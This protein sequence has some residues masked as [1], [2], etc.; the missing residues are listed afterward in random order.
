MSERSSIAATWY[1]WQPMASFQ[2]YTLQW[3]AIIVG[4]QLCAVCTV[5]ECASVSKCLGVWCY[6]HVEALV[7]ITP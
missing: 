2:P 4:M 3:D 7:Q 5:C 6:V 1:K